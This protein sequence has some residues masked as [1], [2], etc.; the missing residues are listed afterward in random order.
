M[1]VARVTRRR[2]KPRPLG[3]AGFS[4]QLFSS[5]R[6]CGSLDSL[7]NLTPARRSIIAFASFGIMKD[8][9]LTNQVTTKAVAVFDDLH[10][11]VVRKLLNVRQLLPP[12]V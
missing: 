9:E 12:V 7:G 6:D 4:G 2:R 3:G 1:L 5:L 10:A 11:D 8:E